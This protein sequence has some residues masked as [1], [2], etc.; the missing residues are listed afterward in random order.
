MEAASDQLTPAPLSLVFEGAEVRVVTIG[1]EPHFV[2]RDVAERLGYADPTSALKQHCKGVAKHHPLQTTGGMQNLRVLSEPDVLRLIM[3][4]TLPA[5]ERFERWV[6]EEVLPSIRR[7]GTYT[8]PAASRMLRAPALAT[9]F[10]AYL[11]IG[12][13]IG[14]DTNQAALAAARA[15]RNEVGQDP[16]A[17]LGVTHL[18]APQQDALLTPTDIGKRLGGRSA[19]QA[20]KALLAGG[21]QA[22]AGDGAWEPTERGRPFAVFSDTGKRHGDGTP[23]RQLRWSAGIVAALEASA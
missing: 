8:A 21:F 13:A 23:V 17:A 16:L 4:S 5:A 10:K 18:L 6:F 20:N 9:T 3:G 12:R 14:L 2:G 22:K 1:E 15:T 11:S 7:T 19:I